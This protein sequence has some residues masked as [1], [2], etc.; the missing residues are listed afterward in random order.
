MVAHGSWENTPMETRQITLY[1]RPACSLCDEAAAILAQIGHERGAA[2]SV[3]HVDIEQ[4]P[5]MHARLLS[6]IPALE[7]DGRLLPHATSR[8]RIE[9]FLA[10][11]EPQ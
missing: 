6:E 8:L 7:V 9:S 4:E 3:T 10:G 2:L 5:A 1:G 11:P